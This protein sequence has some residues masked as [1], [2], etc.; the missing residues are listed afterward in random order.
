MTMVTTRTTFH[1]QFWWARMTTNSSHC[2]NAGC[3]CR[4]ASCSI[5][6]NHDFV[7]SLS[8]WKLVHSS[9]IDQLAIAVVNLHSTSPTDDRAHCSP[10]EVRPGSVMAVEVGHATPQSLTDGQLRASVH[11]TPVLSSSWSTGAFESTT[12][13][14][15]VDGWVWVQIRLLP[16]LHLVDLMTSHKHSIFDLYDQFQTNAP[17]HCPS[18][19]LRH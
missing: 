7:D 12:L 2:W 4:I 16:G 18:A 15:Q 8:G 6:S 17:P 13:V 3:H 11:S 14:L 9:A 10:D 5:D 1:H 19:R